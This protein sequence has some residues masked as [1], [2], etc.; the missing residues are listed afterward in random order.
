MQAEE[1]LDKAP[2]VCADCANKILT[3]Q[4]IKVIGINL[5]GPCQSCGGAPC[6][7]IEVL[8]ADT[9]DSKAIE[10]GTTLTGIKPLVDEDNQ[11]PTA[12]QVKAY[13]HSKS[14]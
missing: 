6:I 8:P 3:K 14:L 11:I 4:P 2:T 7:E 12:D 5:F 1:E 10:P 9:D 13:V